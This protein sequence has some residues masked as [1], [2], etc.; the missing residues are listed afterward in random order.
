MI[1]NRIIFLFVLTIFFGCTSKEAKT[2]ESTSNVPSIKSTPETMEQRQL[3]VTQE[4]E[5]LEAERKAAQAKLIATT[6]FYTSKSGKVVYNKAEIDPSF[7]GGD[8]ALNA[9]LKDNLKFPSD[10]REEGLEGTVFVDFIIDA[11]GKVTEATATSHTYEEADK[12]FIDEALRVVNLMPAW[13]PGRQNG[14]AV[15]VKH[16]LPITFMLQ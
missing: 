6:P 3:R 16:S 13:V 11:N 12:M 9:F 10:A 7:L 2:E 4:R 8:A 14:K 1:Q 15:E 5:R